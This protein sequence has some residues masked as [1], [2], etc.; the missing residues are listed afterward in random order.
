MDFADV[1]T[2]AGHAYWVSGFTLSDSSGTAP[3][4][5]IDVRSEGFG[6]GDPTPS[7]VSAGTGI[8]QGGA[9]APFAYVS[10]TQTWG[11]VPVTKVNDALD[12][13]ATNIATVTIDPVRAH[14]DCNAIINEPS[15]GPKV[16]L[17]GC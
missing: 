9:I 15:D 13:T 4:G 8:L 10:E 12:I 17:L 14:V 3:L 6:V 1:G 11:A 16:T 5:Q 7:G 2:A